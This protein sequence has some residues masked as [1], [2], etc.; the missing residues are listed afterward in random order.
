MRGRGAGVASPMRDVE[1]D[2]R[3]IEVWERLAASAVDLGHGQGRAPLMGHLRTVEILRFLGAAAGEETSLMHLLGCAPCRARTAELAALDE[4]PEEGSVPLALAKDDTAR[5]QALTRVW[6]GIRKV[7]EWRA[8]EGERDAAQADS[9]YDA[10]ISLPPKE[11]EQAVNDEL[12]FHSPG[13]A[14]LLIAAGDQVRV[15]ELARAATLAELALS[16]A[17]HLELPWLAERSALRSSAWCLLGEARWRSGKE[18]ETAFRQAQRQLEAEP[19]DAH[20]RAVFCLRLALLRQEA[21]RTDEALALLERAASLFE[22]LEDGLG[23]GE[24]LAAVGR[25]RLDEGDAEGART[26]FRR[27]LAALGP[28]APIE[29]VL[30]IRHGLALVEAELGRVA[31]ANRVIE[32]SRELYALLPAEL[33]RLRAEAREAEIA[34]LCGRNREA[35]RIRRDAIER[36]REAGASYDA[37]LVALDLARAYV[38]EERPSELDRLR[39]EIVPLAGSPAIPPRA[40]AAFTLAFRIAARVGALAHVAGFLAR[41]RYSP[42]L[43]FPACSPTMIVLGWNHLSSESRLEVCQE[44]G[45]APEIAELSAEEIEPAV[46]EQISWIYQCLTSVEI[47]FEK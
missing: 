13:L 7:Q 37:L 26:A 20:A 6:E 15:S 19:L 10:L 21:E 22:H 17:D 1:P 38:E 16:I 34:E 18:A 28:M 5:G 31:Q 35:E 11:R 14:R 2:D 41:C 27:G 8:T 25:L 32:A 30:D 23:L 33:D 47:T 3:W 43:P 24:T 46:R 45:V 40:R 39:A 4:T 12:R 42:E 29:L 36:F 44:C 9:L